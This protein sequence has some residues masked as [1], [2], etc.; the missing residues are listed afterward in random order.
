MRIEGTY[1][2][3]IKAICDKS[4]ANIIFKHE[5][6]KVFPLR[7]EQDKDTHSCHF[8]SLLFNIVLEVLATAISQEKEK[9][10]KLEMK[11]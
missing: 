11:K 9:E 4:T 3:I 1:A 7:Q 10:S 6:Q 2:K 8:Y 5:K